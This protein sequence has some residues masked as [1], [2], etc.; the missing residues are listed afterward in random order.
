M[1][2]LTRPMRLV[3]T[4]AM[5]VLGLFELQNLLEMLLSQSR[6]RERAIHGAQEALRASQPQVDALL[7]PG[8]PAAWGVALQAALRSTSVAE[9]ELFTL[10]GQRLAAQPRPAPVDHWLPAGDVRALRGGP[11]ITVG[12]IPG[13]GGRLLSYAAARSGGQD[14]VLRL[15]TAASDL[16]EDL[17]ERRQLLVGHGVAM[18][19]LVIVAILATFPGRRAA[20]AP[21]AMD[22]YVAAMERLR[23]HGE[24]LSQ[25]H[26]ALEEAM[27]DREAMARA[28]GLTAGM[29]HE[30]RNGLGTILGYA[31]LVEATGSSPPAVDAAGRIREECEALAAVIRRLLDLGK[32]Q[33]A[34]L[35]ALGPRRM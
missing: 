11:A 18:V 31:R 5:L 25:R 26:E 35:G 7:A 12:P 8:G 2:D 30:V 20:S 16:V 34:G 28:G 14:V 6:V 15:A 22:A 33:E 4:L 27:Q 29:V 17:Q 1:A 9:A 13:G 21:R 19:R 10:G 3:L 32:R 24:A 23:D